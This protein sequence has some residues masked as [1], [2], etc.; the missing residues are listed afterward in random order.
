MLVRYDGEEAGVK[1]EVVKMVEVM[2]IMEKWL[3]IL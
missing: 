3:E 2:K 1:M